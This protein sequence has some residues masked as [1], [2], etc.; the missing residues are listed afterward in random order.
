MWQF[1]VRPRSIYLCAWL[2]YANPRSGDSDGD[3]ELV[4]SWASA[5]VYDDDKDVHLS[6]CLMVHDCMCV[7]E[8]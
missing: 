2:R 1:R 4:I 7:I 6:V 8:E 5:V 3:F